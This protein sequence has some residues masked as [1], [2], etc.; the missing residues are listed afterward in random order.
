MVSG[1]QG[2][3]SPA[4][5]GL[6]RLQ[7]GIKGLGPPL[8]ASRKRHCCCCCRAS[9]NGKPA[10]P[11]AF[12]HQLSSILRFV[13][14]RLGPALR[15]YIRALN[16]YTHI[17]FTD[18][19]Y[20]CTQTAFTHALTCALTL[21]SSCAC[22]SCAWPSS[23]SCHPHSSSLA[24]AS[25]QNTWVQHCR[26]GSNNL[27]NGAKTVQRGQEQCRLGAHSRGAGAVW[28]STDNSKGSRNNA[29]PGE[30]QR[31]RIA[32]HLATRFLHLKKV[33]LPTLA[34]KQSCSE[35][36]L[37]FAKSPHKPEQ[38]HCSARQPPST[39]DNGQSTRCQPPP[40][41]PTPH[42]PHHAENLPAPTHLQCGK[43]PHSVA[44]R[45]GAH[46]MR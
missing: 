40:P 21:S 18:A 37:T 8:Q 13:H 20:V 2:S 41:T 22:L 3:F 23:R 35:R 6:L 43:A 33:T 32:P 28:R 42:P 46:R 17:A 31:Q 4:Q 9:V 24:T 5:C 26:G 7:V 16:T 39:L 27:G 12:S 45:P 15:L 1:K 14:A 19:H 25:S 29:A 30:T 11:A 36:D 34:Q 10:E 44:Q 38:A